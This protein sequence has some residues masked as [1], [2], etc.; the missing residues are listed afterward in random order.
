MKA[1]RNAALTVVLSVITVVYI[2]PIV[3]VL[4]NSFKENTFVKTALW[5]LLTISKE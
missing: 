4:I 1:K 2:L 5:D 3:I